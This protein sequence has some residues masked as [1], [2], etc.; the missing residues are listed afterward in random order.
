LLTNLQAYF[1]NLIHKP[2]LLHNPILWTIHT[3]VYNSMRAIDRITN[4]EKLYKQFAVLRNFER[5]LPSK[6][7]MI[8][9]KAHDQLSNESCIEE[10]HKVGFLGNFISKKFD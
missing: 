2:G 4:G 10:K 1:D 9:Q 7:L 5:P 3:L 6:E 8:L